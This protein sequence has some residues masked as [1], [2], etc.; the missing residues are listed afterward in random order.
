MFTRDG[1]YVMVAPGV[2][3]APGGGQ[4][5]A[6]LTAASLDEC[7]E[8]CW[9]DARCAWLDHCDPQVGAGA[10]GRTSCCFEHVR[11]ARAGAACRWLGPPAPEAARQHPHRRRR[12]LRRR[13]A[14][15]SAPSA[16]CLP[17][18][19]GWS[20]RWRR[21]TSRGAPQ[22]GVQAHCPGCAALRLLGAGASEPVPAKSGRTPTIPAPSALPTFPILQV[23]RRG[24]QPTAARCPTAL[25]P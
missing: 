20:L 14:R 10:G 24:Q 13:A 1:G 5:L 25:L 12:P 17:A 3:L 23:C 16:C 15:S 6:N 22:V 8:A 21:A 9:E 19:A 18:G 4:P 7:A 11:R 2:A